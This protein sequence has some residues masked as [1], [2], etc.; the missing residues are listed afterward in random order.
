MMAMLHQ[1]KYS[2][3]KKESVAISNM[4]KMNFIASGIGEC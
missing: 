4:D 1:G 2:P 3:A